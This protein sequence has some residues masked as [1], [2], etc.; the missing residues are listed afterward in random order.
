[1]EYDEIS[2]ITGKHVVLIEADPQT[3]IESRICMESGYTTSEK[4]KIGSQDVLDY[5]SAG[6]TE[7]MKAV[8]HVDESLGTIWYPAFIQMQ[9]SMLYCERV[10]PNTN[11]LSWKVARVVVLNEKE[12]LNYPIPG[13]DNEYYSSK[14]DVENALTFD[15]FQFKAAL[16]QCYAYAKENGGWAPIDDASHIQKD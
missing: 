4:L 8:R 15:R 7:F 14:L 6:M 5:E 9:G 11:I 2:P 10:S 13:K 16:D 3:G 12:K 1:M